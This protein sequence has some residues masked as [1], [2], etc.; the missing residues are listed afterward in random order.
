MSPYWVFYE[1]TT[2]I[3]VKNG[4]KAKS[5][6]GCIGESWWSKRWVS[7]LESFDLG[8]RLSRG[9]SYARKGQVISIDIKAGIVRAKVQGSFPRPYDVA[10]KLEP[11]SEG[12]WKRAVEVMASKAIFSARLLSGEMPQNIEEAFTDSGVSLFPES[13]EDLET[14]CTCPDW[15]NPCKHIAA[16]YYLLAEE[17][18]RD[19]FLIFRLRGKEKDEIIKELRAL[20][21]SIS[22]EE[23]E[24]PVPAPSQQTARRPLEDCLES[25]WLK[26]RALDSL[27]INPRRPDVENAI[28]KRLGDSPISIGKSNLADLLKIAYSTAGKKALD[29]ASLQESRE[30]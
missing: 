28:L 30:E 23:S 17:F 7:V 4:L 18:D 11:L 26:G 20:R 9:K 5:K 21:S 27:E 10:I 16:V 15:S 1:K 6:R 24:G 22:D 12:D 8:A 25:F 29:R 3:A 14:E 19:P 2:P 13:G